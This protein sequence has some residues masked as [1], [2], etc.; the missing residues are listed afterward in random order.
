MEASLDGWNWSKCAWIIFKEVSPS[1]KAVTTLHFTGA[2]V[3]FCWPSWLFAVPSRSISKWVKIVAVFV[4]SKNPLSRYQPTNP[5][6]ESVSTTSVQNKQHLHQM[7]ATKTISPRRSQEIQQPQT[8]A[9]KTFS[10][11]VGW[12][13]LTLASY[14]F[15]A[16][17]GLVVLV[18]QLVSR[19]SWRRWQTAGFDSPLVRE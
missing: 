1:L 8:N 10:S 3:P 5:D 11:Q 12:T 4:S 18:A 9:N 7:Q 2:N 17:G 19:R 15:V 6:P 14:Y 13:H 16:S